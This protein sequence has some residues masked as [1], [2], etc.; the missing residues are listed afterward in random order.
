[1]RRFLVTFLLLPILPGCSGDDDKPLLTDIAAQYGASYCVKLEQ[2]MGT[3]DFDQAYP[4]GQEDCALR[5]FRIH[6][7]DERSLCTQEQWD[8]CTEDLE[9]STCVE[10][11]GISRPKIPDSCQGC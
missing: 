5:T 6:G 7:T 1:M 3:S 11:D 10:T 8:T 9:K 2:C 4:G